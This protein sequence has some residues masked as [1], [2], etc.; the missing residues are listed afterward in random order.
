MVAVL[1]RQSPEARDSSVQLTS[2]IVRM[3]ELG[4]QLEA[5]PDDQEVPV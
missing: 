5:V 4:D 3:Q 2:M 1:R